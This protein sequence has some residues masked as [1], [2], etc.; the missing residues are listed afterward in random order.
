[1]DYAPDVDNE[2]NDESK[3][4][5]DITPKKKRTRTVPPTSAAVPKAG[6]GRPRKVASKVESEDVPSVD[7]MQ[8]DEY[9][10]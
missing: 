1:M 2:D 7:A 6:R 5:M 10:P 9:V 3:V 8:D 4:E